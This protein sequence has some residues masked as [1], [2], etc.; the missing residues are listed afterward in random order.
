MERV[1]AEQMVQCRVVKCNSDGDGAVVSHVH[2]CT[3]FVFGL[4]F[5]PLSISSSFLESP[6]GSPNLTLL[7][8]DRQ[9]FF[10][11]PQHAQFIRLDSIRS[12]LYPTD[13]PTHSTSNS[14][15]P[16]QTGNKKK[17]RTYVTLVQAH[18]DS[19]AFL[20][21]HDGCEDCD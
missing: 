3:V 4:L 5:R 11:H 21:H 17:G 2:C 7:Q 14:T 9:E 12:L 6:I 1:G 18:R 20:R 16:C 8:N 13:H 10:Q 19:G 15:T